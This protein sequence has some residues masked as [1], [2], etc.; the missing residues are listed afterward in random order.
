MFSKSGV[1]SK[2]EKKNT[3][4]SLTIFSE[5]DEQQSFSSAAHAFSP[6]FKKKSKIMYYL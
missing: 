4:F 2:N 1:R 6:K 5:A 3:I